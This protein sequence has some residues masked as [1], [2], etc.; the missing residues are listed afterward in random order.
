MERL[1]KLGFIGLGN[2]RRPMAVCLLK[3]GFT[4]TVFDVIREV[5]QVFVGFHGARSAFCSIAL[6]K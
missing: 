1:T 5:Q 4:L 6:N 3:A 2:M